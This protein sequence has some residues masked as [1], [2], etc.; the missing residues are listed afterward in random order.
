VHVGPGRDYVLDISVEDPAKQV[1][2]IQMPI[3][4]PDGPMPMVAPQRA[5]RMASRG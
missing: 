5:N 3:R 4:R 1:F 2:E